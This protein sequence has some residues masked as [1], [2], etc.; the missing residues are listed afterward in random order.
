MTEP[1]KALTNFQDADAALAE[2]EHTLDQMLTLAQLSA[3]DLNV[4]RNALQKTLERLQQKID[5]IAGRLQQ[6]PPAGDPPQ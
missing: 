6:L 3:S 1:D 5:C 4:D 2:I